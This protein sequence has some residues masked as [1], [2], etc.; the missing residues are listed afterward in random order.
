MLNAPESLC[1][2]DNNFPF[3]LLPERERSSAVSGLF[4]KTHSQEPPTHRVLFSTRCLTMICDTINCFLMLINGLL[5][6]VFNKVLTAFYVRIL[7]EIFKC[8]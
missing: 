7:V 6:V 1:P 4:D 3:A 2:A 8:P 5:F